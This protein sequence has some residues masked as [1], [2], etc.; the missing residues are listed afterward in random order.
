MADL[1]HCAGSC[2]EEAHS[3]EADL[4][5]SWTREQRKKKGPTVP[6]KSSSCDLRTHHQARLLPVPAPPSDAMRGSS[7]Q[8]I[9]MSTPVLWH[10]LESCPTEGT[11]ALE[12]SISLSESPLYSWTFWLSYRMRKVTQFWLSVHSILVWPS[13]VFALWRNQKHNFQA[14]TL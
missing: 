8:S 13:P 4:L 14:S 12:C 10:L 3:S 1:P 6:F 9:S 5:V 2:G 11:P 7:L